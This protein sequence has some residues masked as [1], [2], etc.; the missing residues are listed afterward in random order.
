[1]ASATHRQGQIPVLGEFK[2]S[3]DVGRAGAANDQR[4][5]EIE[6]PVKD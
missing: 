5:A 6:R 3:R 1:M 2:R 4:R